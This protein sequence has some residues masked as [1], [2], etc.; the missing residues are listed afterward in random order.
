LRS[1]V[2]LVEKL[3]GIDGA[4]GFIL[5]A[6]ELSVTVMDIAAFRPLAGGFLIFWEFC[7]E[8]GET[9]A[10]LSLKHR[11]TRRGFFALGKTRIG[12][13]WFRLSSVLSF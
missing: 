5:T 13:L 7:W 12:L 1:P 2:L 10:E 8:C 11:Q 6:A 4:R 9:Y 3:L